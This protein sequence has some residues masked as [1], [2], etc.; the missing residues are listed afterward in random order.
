MASHGAVV[1]R[2]SGLAAGW[3]LA[4][5]VAAGFARLGL[6]Q[7]ERAVEKQA[8]LEAADHVLTSRQARPLAMA[9]A[10]DR[11]QELDWVAGQGRFVEAPAVLLDNQMREGRPG[12]RAYRLLDTGQASWLLV[13]LGWLPLPPDRRLPAVARPGGEVDVAGLLAPPR[14][15]GLRLGEPLGSRGDTLLMV[16]MDLQAVQDAVGHPV[17]SRVLRLDPALP[18]GFERDLDLLPNTLPPEKHRGYALQW[19]GLAAAVLVTALLLT[20]RALRRT[21]RTEP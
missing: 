18:L 6:W 20:V 7:S 19:F 15:A 2:K 9:D 4:L 5:L 1:S 11:R 17:A 3:V 21:R 12:V 16:R 13:E 14:S 10:P 8:L